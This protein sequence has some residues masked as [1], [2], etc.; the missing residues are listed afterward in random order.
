MNKVEEIL[1]CTNR[2]L[3]VFAYFLNEQFKGP[4]RR[5][6]NPLY[7]DK[8]PSCYVYLDEKRNRYYIK[9]FGQADFHGDC[10]FFVGKLFNLSCESDD[11]KEILSIIENE[12]IMNKSFWLGVWPGLNH[13]HYEYISNVVRNYISNA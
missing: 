1:E 12:V 9:D 6:L 7:L 3:L 11:F 10:F 2:G 5:F 4:G 8:N 13:T